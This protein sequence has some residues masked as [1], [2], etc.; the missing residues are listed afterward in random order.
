MPY[1]EQGNFYGS[2]DLNALEAKY[3]KPDYASQ[4]PGQVSSSKSDKP[5]SL[6]DQAV[7]ALMQYNP[8]MMRKSL[9]E[10]SGAVAGGMAL[11]VVAPI[12][13]GIQSLNA[14]PGNLYRKYLGE[15]QVKTPTTEELM[16]KY[17]QAIA[18]QTPLGRDMVEG[19][20]KAFQASKIEGMMGMPNVVARGVNPNDVRVAAGQARQLAKE[21]RETPQDFQAAQSGLKRQNLYGED[22]IGV[23]AQAAADSLAETL[24]RRKSDGKSLIPG[25]PGAL[26]PETSM[27]AVRPAK[28]TLTRPKMTEGSEGFIPEIYGVEDVIS[29][30]YGDTPAAK[31]PSTMVMHEYAKRFLPSDGAL[32]PVRE[33]VSKF[34]NQKIAE[35]FPDAPSPGH[36]SRAFDVGFSNREARNAKQLEFV[37]EFLETPEGQALKEQYGIPSPEEFTQRYGEAERVIKGPFATFM[38]RNVGA[39]GDALAKLARK[40]ITL[41]T[42]EA[43]AD[44]A[45]YTSKPQLAEKRIKAGFPALGSFHEEH[46]AKTSELDVLNAEIEQLETARRPLFEQAQQR[47]EDPASI[48]EYAETTNPLRQKLR[49]REKLQE[50]IGNIKMAQNVENINDSTIKLKST[51]EM[52]DEIPYEQRQFYPSV[53]RAKPEEMHYTARGTFLKDSG[54][55]K[56]GKDLV[57]DILTGKAGDTSK[58]T[59]ENFIRDKHL[60]RVEAQKLAQEAQKQYISLFDQYN[61]ERIKTDPTAK[62][63]GP[64]SV[65]TLNKDTPKDVALRDVSADTTALNICIGEGCA[66]PE[67]YKNIFTGKGQRRGPIIDATTGKLAPNVRESASSSYVNNLQNGD[68]LA[69]FLDSETG[70]PTAVIELNK[71]RD[72]QYRL[73]YASGY[74]NGKVDA[75]YSSSVR[76]Y[77][78]ERADQISSTGSYLNENVGVYDTSS[79]SEWRK[80]TRDAGLSADQAKL[81]EEQG[82]GFPRF[83]TADDIKN[84]AQGVVPPKSTEVAGQGN[85]QQ[86]VYQISIDDYPSVVDGYR[87]A[88][89]NA[90]EDALINSGLER[91]ERVES[92][93]RA[94]ADRLFYEHLNDSE[95]FIQEPIARLRRVDRALADEVANRA[96]R[97]TEVDAEVSDALDNFYVDVRGILGDLERRERLAAERQQAPAPAVQG[98][99]MPN[100]SADDLLASH[101]DRMTRE[102]RGWLESF[103]RNWEN[104]VDDTPAGGQLAER[105][106]DM[107]QQWRQQNT[108]MPDPLANL[109][110]EFVPDE[111]HPANNVALQQRPGDISPARENELYRNYVDN[112]NRDMEIGRITEEW[113][114]EELADFI[115]GDDDVGTLNVTQAERDALATL[116]ERHGLQD[117][118]D[119]RQVEAAPQ[120]RPQLAV[121]DAVPRNVQTM[122]ALDLAQGL[123]IPQQRRAREIAD[124]MFRDNAFDQNTPIG[125]ATNVLRSH[126]IG[127]AEGAGPLVREQAARNLEQ[128][129]TAAQQDADS[130]AQ[131]LREAFYEDANGPEDAI[132]QI[133]RDI[134][135]LRMRGEAAWEDLVGPMAEDMPWNPTLQAQLLENMET[136]RDQFREQLNGYAKG[137]R[138]KKARTAPL[139][140]TRRNPELAEMTYQYGGM[141]R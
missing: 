70:R 53:T 22:T 99:P 26:T 6:R 118:F 108:L 89:D 56:L 110:D 15:E 28:S 83:V 74:E 102:Q 136:I 103:N 137:G 123:E 129:Y 19:V 138:V 20:G 49:Q 37:S 97:G 96:N 69:R 17:G 81:L 5:Q 39:E 9:Q 61:Q 45:G 141:V 36:A 128:M 125:T 42:P 77:L 64:A 107:Y 101:S 91:P 86:P 35:M 55:E 4:I 8:L 11:P 65:I 124:A 82:G 1:D 7:S 111:T 30:V 121:S 88:L 90:V 23:K 18:P 21:L 131:S 52:L 130:I 122:S 115:R 117:D 43:I 12:S 40:G 32:A 50:D 62:N 44:L 58:L 92:I 54:F 51:K 60:S 71:D 10:A 120:N 112:F 116:V 38:S 109:F 63:L 119:P 41:D 98:E 48:P 135:M 94:V 127:P 114:P 46:L 14:L 66:M 84:A 105:M 73:G 2:D 75:K 79:P 87:V 140:A 33:A 24:E 126:A 76:D 100:L 67:G 16:Q 95:G 85:A 78:N 59:I 3:T 31:M 57:E 104:N 134:G 113:T 47:G 72:G 34:S 106:S 139:V 80:A 29:N 68:E 93:V 13:A 132:T 133:E 27:Y 25:L